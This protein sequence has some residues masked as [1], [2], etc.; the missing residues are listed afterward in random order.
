MFLLIRLRNGSRNSIL[1]FYEN[2]TK[3]VAWN[4]PDFMTG[5]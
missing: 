5:Y 2:L 3:L 1:I 4:E